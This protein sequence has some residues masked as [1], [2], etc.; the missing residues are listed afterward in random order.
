MKLKIGYFVLAIA[1]VVSACQ[2][3]PQAAPTVVPPTQTPFIITATPLPATATPL[4]TV[5]ATIT[6]TEEATEEQ[7]AS[8]P[9]TNNNSTAKPVSNIKSNCTAR[10]DWVS[11]TVK[12][13][14]SLGKLATYTGSTVSALANA[15]CLINP[16]LIAVGQK[17]RLP[18]Q[19]VVPDDEPDPIIENLIDLFDINKTGAVPGEA[20]TFSWK[21]D[22]G[23]TI[24][25]VNKTLN[26]T[27]IGNDL[28]ATGALTYTIP[29]TV[30]PDALKA[31][32]FSISGKLVRDGEDIFASP[33]ERTISIQSPLDDDDDD[34]T[35]D[36][37]T[38]DDDT[39]DDD[40][41]DDDTGDDDTDNDDT[42][43][44]DTGDDDTGDDDTGD[45]T[46]DNVSGTQ[47]TG[48]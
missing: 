21:A 1:V 9:Q 39:G 34:D 32:V 12:V 8:Q 27:I 43:D 45:D 35:G 6:P 47:K 24:S 36:D 14:D 15:N 16:N 33:V 18:K 44:D 10:Q 41:G 48:S 22:A 19:P 25:I 3:E 17:L 37:D 7:P 31:M 26:T 40:T 28:N 5:T 30:D 23:T 42:G 38:G 46:S 11:Y 20:V 29:N 13:G 4:P 2:A